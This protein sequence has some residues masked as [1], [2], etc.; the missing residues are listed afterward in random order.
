MNK[1]KNVVGYEYIAV[2]GSLKKGFG[3]HRLIEGSMFIDSGFTKPEYT[4]YSLGGFPGLH[5]GKDSV[6][7]E[8]Y[9]VDNKTVLPL[10]DSL[11]GHPTWYKR[12]LETVNLFDGVQVDAWLYTFCHDDSFTKNHKEI[13]KPTISSWERPW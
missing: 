2:Y 8:V 11:E 10:L 9:L 12:T 13:I 4:M 1:L 6:L 3:N 7:V 5:I